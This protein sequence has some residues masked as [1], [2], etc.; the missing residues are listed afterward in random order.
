VVLADAVRE[1]RELAADVLRR[2]GFETIE[3]ASGIEALDAAQVDGVCL[4]I[5]EVVLPEMT[6][7]EVCRELREGGHDDLAIFFLSSTHADPVDR[8]AGL[9]FGADDFVVK[10]FHPEELIARVSR[11]VARRSATRPVDHSHAR[12][13]LTVRER[14]VL[15]LLAEGRSQ[16]AIA[17]ALTISSKTVG[18]H[19]QNLLVKFGVHSR[20]ELVANAY[21]GGFVSRLDDGQLGRS[22]NGGL[23]RD[24]AHA[25]GSRP[26][27]MGA[28]RATD[29]RVRLMPL[30]IADSAR[31][32]TRARSNRTTQEE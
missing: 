21:R 6:G 25:V 18:T 29:L 14:E 20:A 7:Y 31:P 3:V 22:G 23:A 27:P 4:V 12:L 8:I 2:A 32:G 5:L 13:R 24:R 26:D 1:D 30:V 10:P 11:F 16:K 15:N 19:I 28:E 17:P 9:L